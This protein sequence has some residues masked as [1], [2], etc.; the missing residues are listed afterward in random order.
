[1]NTALLN[2]QKPELT[3]NVIKDTIEKNLKQ[4]REQKIKVK[5]HDLKFGL[6]R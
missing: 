2:T 3:E 4:V 5:R 1:M 6:K